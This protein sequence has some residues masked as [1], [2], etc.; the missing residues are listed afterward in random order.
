MTVYPRAEGSVSLHGWR[1]ACDDEVT[2]Q[3]IIMCE[4]RMFPESHDS[5]RNNDGDNAE[6]RKFTP[7]F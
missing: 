7:T 4:P 6:V 3:I 2:T 1:E 5:L